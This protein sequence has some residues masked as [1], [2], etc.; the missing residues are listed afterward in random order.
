M[1]REERQQRIEDGDSNTAIC[2]RCGCEFTYTGEL[3]EDMCQACSEICYSD[4][5]D[6]DEEGIPVNM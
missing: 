1:D 2:Q 6:T 4:L 3:C 5:P